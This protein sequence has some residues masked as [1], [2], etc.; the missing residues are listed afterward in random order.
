MV[1]N[2][3]ANGQSSGMR[4]GWRR[5]KTYLRVT[6]LLYEKDLRVSVYVYD[7]T[8]LVT[9]MLLIGSKVIVEASDSKGEIRYFTYRDFA[10]ATGELLDDVDGVTGDDPMPPLR[11]QK[12]RR[13]ASSDEDNAEV[14]PNMG[15]T[16]FALTC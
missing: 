14:L 8:R 1:V 11:G 6:R 7:I 10:I 3:I 5:W 13:A 15:S 9:L 4:S 12:R 16:K 2:L